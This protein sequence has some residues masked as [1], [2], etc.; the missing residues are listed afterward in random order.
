MKRWL[1]LVCLAA[2]AADVGP[3]PAAARSAPT[4]DSLWYNRT[5]IY[6]RRGMCFKDER[7]LRVFGQKCFR[8]YGKLTY[9]DQRRVNDIARQQ[10][11]LGCKTN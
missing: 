4:C 5:A 3:S 10:R 6:A 9:R 1:L 2:I 8:P 11:R 7:A